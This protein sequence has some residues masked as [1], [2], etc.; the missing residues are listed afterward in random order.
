M[1]GMDLVQR[2]QFLLEERN[3]R[4]KEIASLMKEISAAT[5]RPLPDSEENP[6]DYAD[7]VIVKTLN[8]AIPFINAGGQL[9]MSEDHTAYRHEY[10]IRL[11]VDFS[12][13]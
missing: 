5:D 2:L 12:K 1:N 10:I 9:I 3:R 11:I 4:T 7:E 13:Q 8:P 6:L